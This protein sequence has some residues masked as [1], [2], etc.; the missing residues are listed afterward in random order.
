[1]KYATNIGVFWHLLCHSKYR[2]ETDGDT[3]LY[4]KFVCYLFLNNFLR[5]QSYLMILWILFIQIISNYYPRFIKFAWKSWKI[6]IILVCILFF[7]FEFKVQIGFLSVQRLLQKL[8]HFD[9]FVVIK[10]G[11]VCFVYA[12][13]TTFENLKYSKKSL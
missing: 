1:M 9:S 6:V 13:K 7:I 2:L 10:I 5:I 4:F 8:N 3:R 11:C 12:L